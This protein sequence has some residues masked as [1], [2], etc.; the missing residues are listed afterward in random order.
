MLSASYMCTVPTALYIVG[1][2]SR[3]GS[4]ETRLSQQTLDN[5]SSSAAQCF[6]NAGPANIVIGSV[7]K[8]SDAVGWAILDDGRASY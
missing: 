6:A 7:S 1:P 8:L 3:C 5:N 2:R 4:N